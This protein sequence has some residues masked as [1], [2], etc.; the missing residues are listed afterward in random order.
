MGLHAFN[1]SSYFCILNNNCAFLK[2]IITN[3]LV[4]DKL[5]LYSKL[6][7]YSSIGIDL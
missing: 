1:D 5:V 3:K 6:I 4:L 2:W 7:T